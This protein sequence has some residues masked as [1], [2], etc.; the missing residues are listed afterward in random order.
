MMTEIGGRG[1][2]RRVLA[3]GYGLAPVNAM[4]PGRGGEPPAATLAVALV[5]EPGQTLTLAPAPIIP[6]GGIPMSGM[7]P[8]MPT[9]SW[10]PRIPAAPAAG[11]DDFLS[12][13]PPAAAAAVRRARGL[14]DP[15][16]EPAPALK[17]APP[18][19][20]P[21]APASAPVAE[22][23]PPPV[24]AAVAP[25]SV[26]GNMVPP[27]R[28]KSF[29]D[30]NM[31]AGF[32]GT[33]RNTEEAPPPAPAPAPSPVAAATITPSLPAATPGSVASGSARSPFKWG[34]SL[35]D[36]VSACGADSADALLDLTDAQLEQLISETASQNGENFA[37]NTLHATNIVREAREKREERNAD[38][39]A[40]LLHRQSLPQLDLRGCL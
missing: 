18:L 9:S 21:P 31:A 2:P 14:P 12:R 19:T 34:K 36:L 39:I 15:E 26:I 4:M 23:A 11:A 1:K 6:I 3:P 7:P 35:G 32:S 27:G 33:V 29:L 17:P 24:E 8:G 22:S 28:A 20:P 25:T 30:P 10:A 37:T 38:P 16:P 5:A 40:R 13:L